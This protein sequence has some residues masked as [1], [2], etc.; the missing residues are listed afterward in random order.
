M[1]RFI[2]LLVVLSLLLPTSALAGK[3]VHEVNRARARQD[4]DRVLQDH[5]WK[6]CADR[7]ARRFRRQGYIKHTT[8]CAQ[9]IANRYGIAGEALAMAWSIR[10]AVRA[11]LHSPAHRA[12]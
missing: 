1:R 4:L 5:E 7:A 2:V 8:V 10:R 11:L 3:F 9:R 12:I 6:P